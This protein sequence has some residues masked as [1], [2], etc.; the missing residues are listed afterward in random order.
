MC[1]RYY[2]AIDQTDKKRDFKYLFLFRK[3]D[4]GFPKVLLLDPGV[5]T[6]LLPNMRTC[7]SKLDPERELLAPKRS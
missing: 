2:L 1:S 7:A 4:R 5:E 6:L 3:R